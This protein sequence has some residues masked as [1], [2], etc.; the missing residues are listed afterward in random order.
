LNSVRIAKN[1]NLA[2]GLSDNLIAEIE[3]SGEKASKNTSKQCAGA[4]TDS[5]PMCGAL[6]I[7]KIVRRK[8]R[9]STLYEPN[10]REAQTIIITSSSV[11]ET[12]SPCRIGERSGR[13]KPLK[14][15]RRKP[16]SEPFCPL[17]LQIQLQPNA[18][19]KSIKRPLP[20]HGFL[21]FNRRNTGDDRRGSVVQND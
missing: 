5:S 11:R 3:A 14:N 12:S 7:R 19:K 8:I 2:V 6:K 13:T 9:R 16:P 18:K 21:F 17:I 4:V 20:T 15:S 1:D 10:R